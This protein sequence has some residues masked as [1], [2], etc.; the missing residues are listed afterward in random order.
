MRLNIQIQDIFKTPL[1]AI[2]N[3]DMTLVS[4]HIASTME[5][6]DDFTWEEYRMVIDHAFEVRAM[7]KL[8]TPR[9]TINW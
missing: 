6:L 2:A 7:D 1:V 4:I 5:C 3:S 9:L 8:S